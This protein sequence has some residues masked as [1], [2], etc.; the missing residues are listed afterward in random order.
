MPS[1]CWKTLVY[2]LQKKAAKIFEA[3]GSSLLMTGSARTG[4][5]VSLWLLKSSGDVAEK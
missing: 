1:P 5:C 3:N 2:P 4:L